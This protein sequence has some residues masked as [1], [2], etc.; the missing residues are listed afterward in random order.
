MSC[1]NRVYG[2]FKAALYLVASLASFLGGILS[3]AVIILRL[4][5][6][7][8]LVLALVVFFLAYCLREERYPRSVFMGSLLSGFLFGLGQSLGI[9]LFNWHSRIITP[10]FILDCFWMIQAYC[11]ASGLFSLAVHSLLRKDYPRGALYFSLSLIIEALTAQYFLLKRVFSFL[12]SRVYLLPL[13]VI[14]GYFVV[15]L[16]YHFYALKMQ[17]IPLKEGDEN[18][19]VQA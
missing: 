14:L 6:P 5:N 7:A 17:K 8:F 18:E 3:P 12:P 11:L 9:F 10:F 2:Q 16:L 4:W 19:R 13:S 15:S 1:A